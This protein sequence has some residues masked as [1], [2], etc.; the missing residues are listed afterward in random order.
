MRDPIKDGAKTVRSL[1]IADKQRQ[2]RG[3]TEA[4]TLLATKVRTRAQQ[5]RLM[6][7]P[8]R[9]FPKATK[10]PKNP[11][12]ASLTNR[13]ETICPSNATIRPSNEASTFLI[14]P[15]SEDSTRL[16]SP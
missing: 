1:K 15:R 3:K 2:N 6:P 7:K 16:I 8:Y 12:P 5:T 11:K 13:N 10:T 14:S 4:D 9:K